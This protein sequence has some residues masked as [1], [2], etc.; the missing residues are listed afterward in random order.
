MS[1]S[2]DGPLT[3]TV[4]PDDQQPGGAVKR[5]RP[6]RSLLVV[7]VVVGLLIGAIA[8]ANRGGSGSHKSSGSTSD[9]G[10]ATE[11]T[12]PGGKSDPTA[13]T[14][15]APVTSTTNGIPGGFAHT[16]QGAQSAA[17]NYAVVLG[18]TE[19][20]HRG[21]R[22]RIVDAIT[23]TSVVRTLQAR[24]D[25]AYSKS[26]LHR[27]GLTPDGSSPHGMT[28]VSRTLPAGARLTTYTANNATVQVWSNGLVGLAGEGSTEPVTNNWFTVTVKLDWIDN[29]W[30]L[31]E[32]TQ[33]EGPSPVDGD[34]VA[35]SANDV[36]RAVKEFGGFTYAR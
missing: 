19:M 29:D 26:F 28:F 33:K 35:S 21:T 36:A 32:T 27:I 25:Q 20:F 7:L 8:I 2:D 34:N 31:V 13:P 16:R 15:V 22:H 4:L 23:D 24:L 12:A 18:S 30:K 11:G 3:R 6:L 17:A 14:G 5:P 1:S 9:G 10:S